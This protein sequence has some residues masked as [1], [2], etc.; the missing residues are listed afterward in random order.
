[1][2]AIGKRS[3]PIS[4]HEETLQSILLPLNILALRISKNKLT[5]D[6]FF[7]IALSFTDW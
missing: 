7:E 5:M 4:T 6:L 2:E 3:N 1:M